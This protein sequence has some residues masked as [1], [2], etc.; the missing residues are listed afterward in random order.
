MEL[1]DCVLNSLNISTFLQTYLYTSKFLLQYQS[2]YKVYGCMTLTFYLR[3]F[4]AA[5]KAKNSKTQICGVV[6]LKTKICVNLSLIFLI[7]KIENIF[8]CH[9]R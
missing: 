8:T 1:E 3:L 7:F 2:M 4:S 6:L 9:Y 5:I